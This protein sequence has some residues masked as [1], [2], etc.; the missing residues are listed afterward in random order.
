MLICSENMGNEPTQNS[1]R[2]YQILIPKRKTLN[3]V[4]CIYKTK[5]YFSGYSGIIDAGV[6][7]LF[8]DYKTTKKYLLRNKV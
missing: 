3:R 2:S 1:G 7:I 8:L 5:P 6:V 4:Q